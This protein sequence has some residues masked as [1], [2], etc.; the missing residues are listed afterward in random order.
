MPAAAGISRLPDVEGDKPVR[1]KFKAYPL[2]YFHIDIAE[3]PTEQGKLYLLVAIDRIT[4]FVFVE[5]HE[6]ATRRV[7]GDFSGT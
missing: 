1:K 3:V 5:W 2:G 6:K 7:A 4:K